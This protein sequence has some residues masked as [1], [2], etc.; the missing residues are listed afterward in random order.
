MQRRNKG[1]MASRLVDN[2]VSIFKYNNAEIKAY[3]VALV[4]WDVK[5]DENKILSTFGLPEDMRDDNVAHN[6][7]GTTPLC[8]AQFFLDYYADVLNTIIS[9][10]E[11]KYSK[12]FA[13]PNG[14]PKKDKNALEQIVHEAKTS[15][16]N[17]L[18]R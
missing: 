14:L 6:F 8:C 9:K 15:E 11:E 16:R 12:G 13:N 18:I 17:D 3:E 7:V 1:N 10:L 2:D 5:N 4:R